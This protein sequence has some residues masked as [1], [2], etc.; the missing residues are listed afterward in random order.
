VG[1]DFTMDVPIG[2]E[3]ETIAKD[4][5]TLEMIAYRDMWGRGTDSYL[6][7]MYERFTLMKEL[8]SEKGSIFV[9]LAY[10][11]AHS[12]KLILD[13]VFGRENFRNEIILKR[14][15]TKNLQQQ[16]DTI[17][18]LNWAH[19]VLFWYTAE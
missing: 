7:M 5:S 3:K 19:D 18:A 9:H 8:L 6:H 11:V 10:P 2:D 12:T 15:I 14:R 1:A 4:Q 13:D 16:F 17:T